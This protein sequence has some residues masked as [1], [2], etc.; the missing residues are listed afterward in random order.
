RREPHRFAW[1]PMLTGG[2]PTGHGRHAI[3]PD[4][5]D[6]EDRIRQARS[7]P[8]VVAIR[9][10]P[11]VWPEE[12]ERTKAG[13]YERAFAAGEEQGIAVFRMVSG[14]LDLVPA[15]A[16]RHPDLRLIVDHVG[17]PQPPAETPDTPP[18][19]RLPELLA[20]AGYGNVA[21]KLCGMQALSHDAYPFRDV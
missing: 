8:G 2:D 5:P 3:K 4:A 13:G 7:R 11:A 20:L 14:H 6:L 18:F 17:L 1:V 15:I 16:E 19:K 9:I 12:V 21:V 10:V